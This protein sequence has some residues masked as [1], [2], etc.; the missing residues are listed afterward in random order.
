MPVAIRAMPLARTAA[1]LAA[2]ALAVFTLLVVVAFAVAYL[3]DALPGFIQDF[4][5]F[6]VG[7]GRGVGHLPDCGP[8]AL[9]DAGL[10]YPPCAPG[11]Y[12]V[13]P[14]CW[15][16]CPA[17]MRDV[18][19]SCQ[20]GSYGRGA[21]HI[22]TACPAGQENDA[23]LCYP[24]CGPGYYGVGP[25]CWQACPP[26]FV[27][28]GLDCLKPAPYGRGTGWWTQAR[29]EAG[30]GGACE[31]WGGLWYPVCAPGF[32]PVGCCV[33]SP[34]CPAGMTDVGVS[35]QKNTYGRGVGRVPAICPAGQE[36]DAGLCYP[37]C[38][39]G[40]SGVGPVCWQNCPPDMRDTGVDCLKNT[41]D[42]G[43]GTIPTACPAGQENQAGLCYPACA[44]GYRGVGPICWRSWGASLAGPPAPGSPAARYERPS[45]LG[46]TQAP[47]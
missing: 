16:S 18:G 20:K 11:Y 47:F 19:V 41:G 17:S 1:K 35:C 43:V 23:G 3:W 32:H 26:G 44:P 22:P 15:E 28:T 45:L 12:G 24:V 40:Y 5:R 8:G 4:L 36:D 2:A 34:D 10:C 13:G 14:V 27:D 21:G 31:E 29:C 33:C 7:Y 9:Y 25:V 37:V 42:R 6:F 30:T 38:A 39:D 46:I